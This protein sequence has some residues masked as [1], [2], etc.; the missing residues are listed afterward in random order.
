MEKEIDEW[1]KIVAGGSKFEEDLKVMFLVFALY[2][3]I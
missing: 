1:Q 3:L 2:I